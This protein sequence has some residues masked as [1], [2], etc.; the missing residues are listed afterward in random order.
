MNTLQ[1][2]NPK[3]QLES[4]QLEFWELNDFDDVIQ[5][6]EISELENQSIRN[7]DFIEDVNY[8]H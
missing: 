4:E 6:F 1:L 7:N 5:S 3:E 2:I 8:Y